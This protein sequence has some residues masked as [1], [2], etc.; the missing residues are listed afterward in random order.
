MVAKPL[1]ALAAFSLVMAGT[2]ASAQS[3]APL[4]VAQ[5][6]MVRH[7]AG[8]NEAAD[9]RGTILPVLIGVLIIGML[10]FVIKEVGDDNDL[11][12]SP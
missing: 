8:L 2:A 3:A 9:L 5:S 6:P 1:L 12:D 7:G 4:S 10:A 11:P